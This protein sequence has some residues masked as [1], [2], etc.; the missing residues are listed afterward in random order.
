MSTSS[1]GQVASRESGY[2]GQRA[3]DLVCGSIL[4]LV[5]APILL[6]AAIAVV[7]TSRGGVIYSQ[8]RLGRAGRPYRI[9]KLRSMTANCE[10]ISGIQWSQRGDSRVTPVGRILRKLHIDEL[11]QLWN[12]LCG[13]MSLVGPRPERPEIISQL[14]PCVAGYTERLQVRPGITGL[15]QI[16]SPA[17]DSI[18][19]VRRKLQLDLA[20][21]A[22]AELGLDLRIAL[23]TVLYLVG[24]SYGMI[25]LLLRL[26][27]AGQEPV[28]NSESD[29][30]KR[31]NTLNPSTATL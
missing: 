24:V 26:P 23:G 18:E 20:Y 11:P 28:H 27:H 12:V 30:L 5:T 29:A 31:P 14:V 17:D 9:Y 10:A 6:L 22:N 1:S 8:T 19:S 2:T 15:A 3:F 25:R 16:Q 4:L 7:T 21:I 13:E